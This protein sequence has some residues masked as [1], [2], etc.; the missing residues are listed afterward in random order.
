MYKEKFA[1]N[2]PEYLGGTGSFLSFATGQGSLKSAWGF[3]GD[4]RA[5]T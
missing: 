3:R 4:Y 5:I 1:R 2:L